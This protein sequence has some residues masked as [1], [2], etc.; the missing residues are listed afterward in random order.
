MRITFSW[1]ESF[2]R[3]PV[4]GVAADIRQLSFSICVCLNVSVCGVITA[5]KEPGLTWE[6]MTGSCLVRVTV[7]RW[8]TSRTT[9]KKMELKSCQT[10]HR[11]FIGSLYGHPFKLCTSLTIM[12]YHSSWKC[13]TAIIEPFK[14][15]LI[16]VIW[17]PASLF[18]LCQHINTI[19]IHFK[20]IQRGFFS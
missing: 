16:A 12:R 14:E 10:S 11:N 9:Y 1:W 3:V 6:Q 8:K 20:W 15:L 5:W 18:L 13:I 7:K 17:F 19:L 4:C 2:T